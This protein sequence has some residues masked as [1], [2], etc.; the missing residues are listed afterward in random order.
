M[1]TSSC[2]AARAGPTSARRPGGS[3]LAG[4]RL[5]R[6]ATVAGC[7]SCLVRVF[8]GQFF[9]AAGGPAAWPRRGR[10]NWFEG[11]LWVALIKAQ[12]LIQG[13]GNRTPQM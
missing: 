3:E 11:F 7:V 4:C 12:L 6:L 8:G 10:R 5:P 13:G 1:D 2:G 9:V